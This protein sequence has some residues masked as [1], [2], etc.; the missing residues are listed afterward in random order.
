MRGD[1]R[2]T[3]DKNQGTCLFSLV[4]LSLTQTGNRKILAGI[5]NN[6]QGKKE[7]KRQ[8]TF[9]FPPTKTCAHIHTNT[10]TLK[11]YSCVYR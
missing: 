1:N 11:T 5:H 8:I 2:T 4:G 9:I 7:N 10:N 6:S 3:D